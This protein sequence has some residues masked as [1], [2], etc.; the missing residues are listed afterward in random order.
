MNLMQS[1]PGIGPQTSMMLILTTNGFREFP[2]W[3]K[4][5]CYSGCA[6]FEYSSGTSVRG[7]TKVHT[8][9]DKKLKSNLYLCVLNNLKNSAEMKQYYE[10]KKE[11]GKHSMLIINNLK[12]K[13]LSR[14]YAVVKRETP[15]VDTYKFAQ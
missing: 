8:Y 2:T 1:I 11:E 7:R 10:R 3:R 5:A 15:Y 6:P 4:M 14:I 9:A 12:C 13:L